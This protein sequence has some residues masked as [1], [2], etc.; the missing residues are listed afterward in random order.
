MSK[1]KTIMA[2]TNPIAILLGIPTFVGI[3][4]GVIGHR[5]G[6]DL[7]TATTMVRDSIEE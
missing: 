1:L 5:L 6:K 2:Y 4:L 7:K 3:V